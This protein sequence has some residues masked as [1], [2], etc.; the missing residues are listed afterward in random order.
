MEL[1][2]GAWAKRSDGVAM[3]SSNASEQVVNLSLMISLVTN[4]SVGKMTPLDASSDQ[5]LSPLTAGVHLIDPFAAIAP[6]DVVSHCRQPKFAGPC[7]IFAHCSGVTSKSS[8]YGEN[9]RT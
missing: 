3:T 8:I 2:V 7:R 9:S 4:Q 6:P 1:M 5:N